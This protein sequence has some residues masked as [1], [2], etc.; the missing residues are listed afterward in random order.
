MTKKYFFLVLLISQISLFA[1]QS[2]VKDTCKIVSV[3]VGNADTVHWT[4]QKDLNREPFTIEQYRWGKWVKIGEVDVL[5]T[6]E[7]VTYSFK[8]IPNSGE[9]QLRVFHLNE[10]NLSRSVKW[11]SDIPVVKFTIQKDIKEIKFTNATMYEILDSKGNIVKKGL[12][13][14]IWYK[15]LPNGTYTLNYDNST[16]KLEL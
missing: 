7:K 16:T 10:V 14:T 11:V 8:S 4:T 9:N 6:L 12:F 15:D 5:K 3:T 1:Q 13:H 2:Q